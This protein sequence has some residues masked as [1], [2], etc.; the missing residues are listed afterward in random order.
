MQNVRISNIWQISAYFLKKFLRKN[1]Q[2]SQK[3]FACFINF[4]AHIQKIELA[5]F[6]L[7]KKLE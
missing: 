2:F 5:F 6:L 3:V 4:A 7:S 1:Q